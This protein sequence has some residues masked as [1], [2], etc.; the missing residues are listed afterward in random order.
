MPGECYNVDCSNPTRPFEEFCSGE[1]W[2]VWHA[3]YDPETYERWREN[4]VSL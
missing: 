3:A 4:S 1:C 2:E